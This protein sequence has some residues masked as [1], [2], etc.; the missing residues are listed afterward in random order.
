V[1]DRLFGVPSKTI[2]VPGVF[3]CFAKKQ[4]RAGSSYPEME[5][6]MKKLSMIMWEPGGVV[7]SSVDP[8]NKQLS[9]PI[10]KHIVP[11]WEGTR[12]YPA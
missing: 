3:V 5:L 10:A 2:R 4:P 6:I 12:G 7:C 8:R 11:E 1:V 9:P